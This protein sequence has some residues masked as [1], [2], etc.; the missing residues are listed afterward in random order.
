MTNNK[1]CLVVMK[2]SDILVE[3][4]VIQINSLSFG[5]PTLSLQQNAVI[6]TKFALRH[7]TAYGTKVM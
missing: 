6:K 4:D 2:G 1:I 3:F 5:R 7:T